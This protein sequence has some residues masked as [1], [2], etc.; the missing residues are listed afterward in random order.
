MSGTNI[1]PKTKSDSYKPY[2]DG[3]RAISVLAVLLFHIYPKMLPGGFIGVDVFF[4]ISGFL[5]TGIL[6]KHFEKG[7]FTFKEFYQR[8]VRRL[9]P[10][11][12]VIKF[13]AILYGFFVLTNQEFKA[14]NASLFHNT[15]FTANLHFYKSINYFDVSATLK[16]FLH[17]WSLSVEEQFYLVFPLLLFI[18]YHFKIRRI[19]IFRLICLIAISMFASNLHLMEFNPSKAYYMAWPRGWEIMT[20]SI[21]AFFLFGKDK[22]YLISKNL[23]NFIPVIGLGLIF[24]SLFSFS[25]S[26]GYPATQALI[27]TIGAALVMLG[28]QSSFLNKTILSTSL[29]TYIGRISYPLYL[30][31]WPLISF[32]NII[33]PNL[34]TDHYIKLI[35]IALSFLIAHLLYSKVEHYI[36]FKNFISTNAL[37]GLWIGTSAITFTLYKTSHMTYFDQILKLESFNIDQA[38]N[39]W[40]YP[41][42]GAE[43]ISLENDKYYF[44]KLGQNHN[45][46][47]F[48]GDS[49]MEEY[50]FYVSS[51]I[52][53]HDTRG[54]IFATIGGAF[55]APNVFRK[56]S[57]QYS[58]FIDNAIKTIKQ[59]NVKT[60]VI[61]ASWTSYFSQKD[62]SSDYFI[63]TSEGAVNL[64]SPQGLDLAWSSLEEMIDLFKSNNIEVYIVLPKPQGW[65]YDPNSFISR[66]FLGNW[67]ID[68]KNGSYNKWRESTN[69][70]Y[71][72]LESI[73]A[74]QG[75]GLL[76][77]SHFLCK[78]DICKTHE[79]LAP[80]YKDGGHLRSTKVETLFNIFDFLFSKQQSR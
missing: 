6:L 77:P 58:D 24:F 73:G 69:L 63:T 28:G 53:K 20:G 26:N 11:L 45:Y 33:K 7:D 79:N 48:L 74:K 76:H 71:E 13:T 67:K 2:I 19:I 46:V 47:M 23:N 41:P 1:E 60:V 31:H 29:L 40:E 34:F 49:H 3:L 38:I 78:G 65:E 56:S 61:S 37:I 16:P 57:P 14:M 75:V 55:P 30:I 80:L 12:L 43:R 72:R 42:K 70:I 36:R 18:L 4:V 5:I 54:V 50:A 17:F 44:H 8:R 27:P 68:M 10:S 22:D 39:D 32:I 52:Q 35:I 51:L 64:G 25:E 59:Y 66:D 62:S 15:K 21:L 9:F